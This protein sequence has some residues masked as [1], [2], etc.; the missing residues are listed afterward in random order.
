MLGAL[1]EPFLI[2]LSFAHAGGVLLKFCRGVERRAAVDA[3]EGSMAFA[4]VL[5]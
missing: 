3:C 1:V 4:I 2:F 5:G